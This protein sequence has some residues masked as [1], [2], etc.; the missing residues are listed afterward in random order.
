MGALPL[1]WLT[2]ALALTPTGAAGQ[3][4]LGGTWSAGWDSAGA[5][6]VV[7][8]RYRL[9]PDTATTIPY[10][11]VRFGTAR[12][13]GMRAAVDGSP[14]TAESMGG[15]GRAERGRLRL[16]VGHG[17]TVELVLR[18]R[19]HDVSAPGTEQFDLPVPVALVDWR[20]VAAREGFFS[21]RFRLPEDHAVVDLFPTVP[22]ERR[23]VGGRRSELAFSLPVPPSLVRIRGQIGP[24]G[25]LTYG[26]RVDL[27]VG[28]LV[29]LL[30]IV[31]WRQLRRTT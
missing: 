4:V 26:R 2:L 22:W 27:A 9:V 8:A 20:P 3:G 25:L 17:D 6:I 14:V 15:S 12:V 19:V 13:G 5:P 24:A 11:V 10:L 18:Y 29:A 1:P 30:G 31:A 23:S 21:A 28:A 7:E 16:P